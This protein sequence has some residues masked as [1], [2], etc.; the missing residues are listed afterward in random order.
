MISYPDV[1]AIVTVDLES[2]SSWL[3]LMVRDKLTALWNDAIHP[4]AKKL[5][6]WSCA[7]TDAG[8]AKRVGDILW[9]W[10]VAPTVNALWL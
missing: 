2:I 7:P 6:T 3:S 4:E 5:I 1:S 10:W 8:S 9:D